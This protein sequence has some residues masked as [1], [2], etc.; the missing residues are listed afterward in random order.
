MSCGVCLRVLFS[1]V[2]WGDDSG[3]L[4]GFWLGAVSGFIVYGG[5]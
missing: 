1:V 2:V 3:G 4:S 5:F